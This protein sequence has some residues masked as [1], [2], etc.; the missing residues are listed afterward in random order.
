MYQYEGKGFIFSVG[1]WHILSGLSLIALLAAQQEP[2]L[3][4]QNLSEAG[5]LGSWPSEM[6]LETDIPLE[7]MLQ[8]LL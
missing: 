1:M 4:F 2:V 3:D 7:N 8:L 5:I 6:Q